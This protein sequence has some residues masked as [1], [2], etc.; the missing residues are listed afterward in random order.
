MDAMA[1]YRGMDVATAK[2]G[3]AARA[4]IPHHG[5]DLVDPSED[6]NLRRFL[7]TARPLLADPA[8]RVLGLVGTPYYLHRLREGLFEAPEADWPLRETLERRGPAELHAELMRLDPESARAIGPAN[9]R[10]LVRALEVCLGTGRPLSALRREDTRGGI[11]DGI[12]VGI[13]RTPGDL[14]ARIDRRVDAMLAEGLVEET[15]RLRAQGLSRTAA[16]AIG[17]K[18]ILAHLQGDC[19]LDEAAER[20][21]IRTRQFARRQLGWFRRFPETD[22]VD[23][24][25]DEEAETL[26]PRL[27]EAFRRA[28]AFRTEAA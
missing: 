5:L 22:W 6:F 13:R 16:Q 7:E 18:E 1:V 8:R 25:P 19:S 17:T 9:L 27:L 21:R 28:G 3:P 26:A 4:R 20:I 11:R 10:R 12:L 14:R 15:R 23:A 2:P 24:A